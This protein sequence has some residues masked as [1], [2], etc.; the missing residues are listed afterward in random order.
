MAGPSKGPG[1]GRLL[2][3]AGDPKRG[4]RRRSDASG[5]GDLDRERLG[6]GGRVG[7]GTSKSVLGPDVVAS[8][9]VFGVGGSN[10][11]AGI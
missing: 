3:G 2:P 11:T 4:D 6:L 9:E 7:T 8:W 1:G 5:A 10:L